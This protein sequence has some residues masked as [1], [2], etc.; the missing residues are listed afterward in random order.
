MS[1]TAGGGQWNL[2][3]TI[4]SPGHLN[5][6]NQAAVGSATYMYTVKIVV[7][8]KGRSG[9]EIRGRQEP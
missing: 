5:N 3:F 8:I 9:L 2:K 1:E 7:C 6:L 4:G